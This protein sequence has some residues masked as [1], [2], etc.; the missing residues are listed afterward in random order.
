MIGTTAT[1]SAGNAIVSRVRVTILSEVHPKIPWCS[2]KV[3]S[4]IDTWLRVESLKSRRPINEGEIQA[5][6]FFVSILSL[7]SAIIFPCFTDRRQLTGV[8]ELSSARLRQ[9]VLGPF[10]EEKK[11]WK[12][13]RLHCR[14]LTVLG[15]YHCP[16]GNAET[17]EPLE[18]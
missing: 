18:K 7:A 10:V 3:F 2:C 6:F 5:G 12:L 8:Y 4:V 15:F 17:F 1:L 16:S 11:G 13:R 14:M 9:P